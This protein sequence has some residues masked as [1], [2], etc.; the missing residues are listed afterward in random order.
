MKDEVI[1][2]LKRIE[3]EDAA[4]QR[5]LN[6]QKEAEKIK[7]DMRASIIEQIKEQHERKEREAALDDALKQ[8]VCMD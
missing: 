6:N 8:K 2:D 5:K 7:T 4:N 1:K 3:M